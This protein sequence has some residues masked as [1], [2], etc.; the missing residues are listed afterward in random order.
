ML[1]VN[2]KVSGRGQNLRLNQFQVSYMSNQ[3]VDTQNLVWNDSSLLHCNIFIFIH[4]KGR[5]NNETKN[6]QKRKENL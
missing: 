6:K 3:W 4:H 1:E 5:R 2:A